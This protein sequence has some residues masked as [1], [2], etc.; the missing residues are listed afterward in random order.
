MEFK[1]N[2]KC[3]NCNTETSIYLSS[4]LALSELLIHGKCENCGNTLQLN[5]NLV[6][7]NSASVKSSDESK[8]RE[9]TPVNL[10]MF[11]SGLSSSSEENTSET[12]R[13]LIE[14]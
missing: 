14:S 8:S 12:I 11:D 1:R 9:D 13:D 10:N 5:Y 7:D 3:S 6:S 4:Q 2:I